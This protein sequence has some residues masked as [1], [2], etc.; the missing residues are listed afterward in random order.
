MRLTH[1]WT[2]QKMSLPNEWT[3]EEPLGPRLL[4]LRCGRQLCTCTLFSVHF[5]HAVMMILWRSTICIRLPFS[6]L[7]SY[8]WRQCL[9]CCLCDVLH[10]F[11]VSSRTPFSLYSL[12]KSTA[13]WRWR[14]NRNKNRKWQRNPWLWLSGDGKHLDAA[15]AWLSGQSSSC[16]L[17]G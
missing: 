13:A 14:I 7:H 12:R 11:F 8:S 17:W 1:V 9:R 6:L 5:S 2:W 10:C 3:F 16:T 15:T 4:S